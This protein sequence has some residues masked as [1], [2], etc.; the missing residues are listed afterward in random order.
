MSF[1]SSISTTTS[2]SSSSWLSDIKSLLPTD[3]FVTLSSP[4]S[5]LSSSSLSSSAF[6][7]VEDRNEQLLFD[8]WNQNINIDNEITSTSTSTSPTI[9]RPDHENNSTSI[10]NNNNSELV[11]TDTPATNNYLTN[12]NDN[13]TTSNSNSSTTIVSL[14]AALSA[15]L[16]ANKSRVKQ[17]YNSFS[18]STSTSNTSTTF[19]IANTLAKNA[20][21]AKNPFTSLLKSYTLPSSTRATAALAA[22]TSATAA[23]T[24]YLL[25][26]SLSPQLNYNLAYSSSS[27]S[28]RYIPNNS[29]YNNNSYLFNPQQQ[30]R[31]YLFGLSNNTSKLSF[32]SAF[33]HSENTSSQTNNNN[34]NNDFGSRRS[35]SQGS[36]PSVFDYL[37][38]DNAN[39]NNNTNRSTTSQ[40]NRD[41]SRS[42]SFSS[43][44]NSN[45]TNSNN[46]STVP[47]GTMDK[48]V[49]VIL[50]QPNA[51]SQ[52]WNLIRQV[53]LISILMAYASVFFEEK[54]GLGKTM[55]TNT[56]VRPE[57]NS[58][59]KFSDVAG[60]DEAKEELAEI[61][62]Y[63]RDP[64]K[65][66]RLGGKLPKGILLF[67]PPGTGKTLLA[68][69]ISN[70]A[71]A[72]FFYASGSEF[73]ELYVGVGSK[74]IRE[75]FAAAKKR[76][77]AIIFIDEIDAIGSSRTARDQQFSKMTLNQ[78]LIEMDG[79]KQNE[80]VIVI[81]ATNFPE[82]LD[83]ALVRP[84][85]FDR[86]VTV[87]L[88][89]VAG[90]MS[91]LDV[92][93]KNVPKGPDVNLNTIARGT[94]GFSG[95]ELAEIV[96]QAALKASVEGKSF[97]S[98]DHLEY[99]KDKIIMGAERKSAVIDDKVKRV[100]AYHEGGH[101]LVALLSKG[102]HPI[103]KATIM[104]RGQALGMVS[105]LPEKDEISV[106]R[107]QL[108]ARLE[109]CMG[110]RVAE[111]MIFGSD[112]ITSGASSDI[113]QATSLA[114][115]MVTKYGMSEK[116]GHVTH[117]ENDMEKL[118]SETKALIEKEVKGL[119]D[120]AYNQ[121]SHILRTH[122][123]E[124]HRIANALIEYET[125]NAE[126][127]NL[128][129]HGKPLDRQPATPAKVK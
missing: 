55:T 77:P 26:A 4:S 123:K 28:S 93:M 7:L 10:L 8:K 27:T 35:Q 67:G 108:Q 74:R 94:P 37:F 23:V 12:N 3:F 48:P 100:T 107:R 20:K 121:A 75:L 118:S 80:G 54:T 24:T 92:H 128:V 97:V 61:V 25:R 62:E 109:V 42:K 79:F 114:K 30:Q 39:N 104:P 68:K 91:I 41:S 40:G 64:D 78:L 1:S 11:I 117:S 81:A 18:T 113:D 36:S 98:M 69:A 88:P 111:E 33:N 122:E 19:T 101:A 115:A 21:N 71:K 96:N 102:A 6:K 9:V 99:A 90:R 58:K 124:L 82:L 126:E 31:R 49:H 73:D 106:T 17:F 129:L 72:A 119:I 125:L 112:N 76:A 5:S 38:S 46:S 65:F 16:L 70:E 47:N 52:F 59:C 60:V 53:A 32:P 29:N 50:S 86:H 2:P 34:N 95:A 85:R 43:N 66:R 110:G 84:G 22:T 87:P 83:K 120:N 105:Q 57:N 13:N 44:Y 51:R 89:D 45:N 15:L 127:L 63:L 56:E 14:T 103:H 116:I